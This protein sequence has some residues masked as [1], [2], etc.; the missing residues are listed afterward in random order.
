MG[1]DGKTSHKDLKESIKLNQNPPLG[2]RG[3]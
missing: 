2:D 1:I 3:I